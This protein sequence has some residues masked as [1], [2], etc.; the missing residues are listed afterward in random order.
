MIMSVYNTLSQLFTTPPTPISS[1]SDSKDKPNR[2]ISTIVL[3]VPAMLCQFL[4]LILHLSYRQIISIY[5]A[6]NTFLK[7]KTIFSVFFN[8][9][10]S[11]VLLFLFQQ[12]LRLPANKKPTTKLQQPISILQSK[13]VNK[14]KTHK[15]RFHSTASDASR[16][17]Q[18]SR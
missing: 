7:S 8:S 1:Q 17:C 9:I 15:T 16:A 11:N 13:L 18:L 14:F 10:C 2:S 5:S 12:F 4:R 6:F 3:Q